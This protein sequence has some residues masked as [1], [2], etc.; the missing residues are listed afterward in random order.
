MEVVSFQCVETH[1]IK[2][3][4]VF[5]MHKRMH[6]AIKANSIY[7]YSVVKSIFK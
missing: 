3:T 4:N 7:N 2:E 1:H 5:L 6:Q